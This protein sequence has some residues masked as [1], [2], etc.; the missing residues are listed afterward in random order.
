[1]PRPRNPEARRAQKKSKNKN[2][3]YELEDYVESMISMIQSGVPPEKITA[4]TLVKSVGGTYSR[5][6][7]IF[8][9]VKSAAVKRMQEMAEE[10]END[11]LPV[12]QANKLVESLP[13]N[14]HQDDNTVSETQNNLGHLEHPIL[15]SIIGLT[16]L[17]KKSEAQNS[18][19]NIECQK[20]GTELRIIN[21]QLEAQKS[22][23]QELAMQ[24]KTMTGDYGRVMAVANQ[25]NEEI[26]RL[27]GLLKK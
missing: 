3:K 13:S 25:R 23:N 2:K 20:L 6:K 17:L 11:A 1:M 24:L 4:T 15:Q 16:E 5:I 19:L 12:A 8:A 21:Q 7:T 26:E 9:E 14:T 18:S 22:I 10:T 27:Y